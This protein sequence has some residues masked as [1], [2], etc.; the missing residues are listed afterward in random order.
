ME[1][2]VVMVEEAA[3][4]VV[5]RSVFCEGNDAAENHVNNCC[6]SCIFSVIDKCCNLFG[7]Q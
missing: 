2:G 1:V 5:A 7:E 3:V 6:M 4:E